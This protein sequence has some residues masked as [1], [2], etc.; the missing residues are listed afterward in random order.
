MNDAIA[1]KLL[2]LK[3]VLAPPVEITLAADV[4]AQNNVVYKTFKLAYDFNAIIA[5]KAETGKNLL[6]GGVW[7]TIP[8]EPAL[9]SAVVW[10]GLQLYHPD[11]TLPHVRIMMPI[12]DAWTV[13]VQK[14]VEAW[15]AATPKPDPKTEPTT[16]PVSVQTEIA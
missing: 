2:N 12:G 9:L 15:K 16:E 4:D 5:V 10:A 7:P 6:D 3:K 8:D 13:L 1:K 11:L 14:I